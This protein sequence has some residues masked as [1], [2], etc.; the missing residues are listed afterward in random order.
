M[1]RVL[2]AFF[3]AGEIEIAAE[4]V[5]NRKIGLQDFRQHFLVELFLEGF[6]AVENGVGVGILGVE[7]GDDFGICFL[8]QPGVVVDAAVVVDDVFDGMAA[9]DRWLTGEEPRGMAGRVGF[10]MAGRGGIRV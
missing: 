8:A 5:G 3:G 1:D 2:F 7:V 9:G 6:G 10:G 4:A